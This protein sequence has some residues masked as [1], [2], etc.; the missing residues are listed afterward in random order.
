MRVAALWAY[1][2]N[3]WFDALCSCRVTDELGGV[4]S[5]FID[6]PAVI[7]LAPS[8]L[9]LLRVLI[10][11]R[12][13]YMGSKQT[14]QEISAMA[15]LRAR[16]DNALEGIKSHS[17]CS[18][19]FLK[20]SSHSPKDVPKPLRVKS[21]DEIFDILLRSDR[22]LTDLELLRGFAYSAKFMSIVLIPW[23][24]THFPSPLEFR[25]F[26]YNK[27]L[28]AISQYEWS[29][30]I[31]QLQD[32]QTCQKVK[33]SILHM[34]AQLQQHVPYPSYVMDIVLLP[35]QPPTVEH[36]TEASPA[37]CAQPAPE[38]TAESSSSSGFSGVFQ[39]RLIELN[40]FF[41]DLSSGSCLF[42]WDTDLPTLMPPPTIDS[43][44]ASKTVLRVRA[45]DTPHY[46]EY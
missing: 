6:M 19:F 7:P 12:L 14:E 42:D 23:D 25:C 3:W 13:W 34:H 1:D 8:E 26:V 4:H 15:S 21:A 24:N 44:T 27:K 46:K 11:K 31:P 18:E 39:P 5:P 9:K 37:T 2:Y 35:L 43:R 10:K 16:V 41:P 32:D 33:S 28:T 45:A 22:I 29:R 38:S 17:R 30:V 40:P 36:T 20:L